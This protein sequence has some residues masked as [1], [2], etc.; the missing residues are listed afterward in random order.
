M[1]NSAALGQT[2]LRATNSFTGSQTTTQAETLRPVVGRFAPSPT[3]PLHFGSLIAATGS[4]LNAKSRQGQWLVRIEDVDEPRCSDQA[5]DDILRTLEAHGFAWD[6]PVWY[7][8]SRGDRYAEALAILK[9]HGLVYPCAC[10]RRQL[11]QAPLAIDGAV[12]YPGTCRGGLADGATARAWRLRVQDAVVSFSDAIQGPQYQNLAREVGDFVLLRADGYFAYQLAVVVD[13]A[14][15]GVT[16]IIRGADLL[17]STA[18]QIYLQQCLGLP[19]PNYGH[20]PVVANGSGE[21]L[22]KQTRAPGI[23]IRQAGENLWSALTFLGQQP[24]AE[25]RFACLSE[26]WQWALQAWQIQSIPGLPKIVWTDPEI[27]VTG[28]QKPDGA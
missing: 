14:E 19:T 7:Q 11:S 21:K 2:A 5:A 25:L 17:S 8:K 3:G 28:R 24:P 16:E 27:V 23:G 12:L 22:S 9:Q 13:D 10:T 4:Y 18:R 20:L 26:L 1:N 6:G 15:Q